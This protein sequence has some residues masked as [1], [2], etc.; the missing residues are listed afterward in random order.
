[1]KRLLILAHIPSPNLAALQ[2]AAER[3]ASK[4]DVEVATAQPLSAEADDLLRADALILGTNENLGSMAGASKDWFDRVYYPTLEEKQGLPYVAYIRA[5]HDGT[6]TK[7][8]LETIVTGLR[9]RAA[10]DTLVFKGAWQPDWLDAL[11]ELA[12]AFATGVETGIF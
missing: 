4:A 6:G 1:M 12:E 8:Q 2:A 9:W 7:R 5:G 3:G 10:Q 11:E